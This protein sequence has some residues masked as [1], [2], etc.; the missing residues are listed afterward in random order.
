MRTILLDY[1][2][3]FEGKLLYLPLLFSASSL[4]SCKYAFCTSINCWDVWQAVYRSSNSLFNVR[5][6]LPH[7]NLER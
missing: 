4:I 3:N 1:G 7:L 6:L 2:Q 5:K